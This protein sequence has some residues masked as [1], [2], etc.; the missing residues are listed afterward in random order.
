[1]PAAVPRALTP[2]IGREED[3]VTLSRL[4][5][6]TRLLTF[7]GAGGSGKTRLAT[8]V[9]ARV[10]HRFADGVS[11]VELAPLVNAE[12]LA[13]YV[14]NTLGVEQG[15]RAPM[16]ALLDTLRERELLLVLDNCEH[17][18]EGCAALVDAL[19]RG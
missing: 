11:W 7:T 14:A 12:L 17:L 16:A 2:F 4:L 10:S 6:T 8:E 5:D 19:L 15:A 1:M 18:V 9:A 13:T 3:V